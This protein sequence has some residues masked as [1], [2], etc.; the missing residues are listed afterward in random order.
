M[1]SAAPVYEGLGI[2]IKYLGGDVR[3]ET[4]ECCVFVG[5]SL[6]EVTVADRLRLQALGWFSSAE[7]NCW[8]LFT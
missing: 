8:A 6:P 1:T 5:D 2:L 3:F 4:T 7:Y